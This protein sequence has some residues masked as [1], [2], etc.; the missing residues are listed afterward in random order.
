MSFQ[1]DSIQGVIFVTPGSSQEDALKLWDHVFPGDTPDGFNRNTSLPSLQSSATGMRAGYSVTVTAQVGR[2][3][4]VLGG[5]LQPGISPFAGPPRIADVEGSAKVVA[6]YLQ[7]LL[8]FTSAI[9]MAMV[10]ELGQT[11]EPGSEATVLQETAPQVPFPP[12]ST[13]LQFQ[14]NKRRNFVCAPELQMNRLYN[15]NSGIFQFFSA[16]L[17]TKPGMTSLSTPY[18]GM[19]I[20][21]NSAQE[22][23]LPGDKAAAVAD[24][25]LAEVMAILNEGFE[26]FT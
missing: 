18:V 20:D 11:I 4:L 15:L 8:P 23:V 19:K 2:I 21:V 26:R 22:S 6:H 24:E 12:G 1:A 14:F 3:D 10:L 13:D 17:G 9:R 16:G 7:Q 25:L 5:Q